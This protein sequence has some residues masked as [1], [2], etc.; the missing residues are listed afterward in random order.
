MNSLLKIFVPIILVAAF[1]LLGSSCNAQSNTN[2][3]WVATWS[4]APQLVETANMPP[5]PGLTNNSLRQILR[6]SIGGDTIAVKLR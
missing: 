5:S 2:R 6:V 4:T 3:K 1:F